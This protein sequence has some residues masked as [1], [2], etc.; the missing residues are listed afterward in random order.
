M[1]RLLRSYTY[2]TGIIIIMMS[3]GLKGYAQNIDLSNVKE[4]I[5]A[6]LK[7]PPVRVN[8]GLSLNTVYTYNDALGAVNLQPF[9][10]IVSGNVNFNIYG[11]N[12]P[13]TFTY[14]NNRVSYTNPSF[15][16]NRFAIHPRYKKWQAH[17]GDISVNYSPYTLS[18]YQ[19]T[20]AAVEYNADKI[21]VQALYGRFAKAVKEDSS[22]IPS[23]KR[24]GWGFRTLYNDGGKKLALTVFHAKD[25]INSIPIPVKPANNAITPMEN[26]A[27]AVEGAYPIL[28]R[29]QV[30]AEYSTSILTRNLSYSGDSLTP[31]GA[32]KYLVGQANGSSSVYHALRAGLNYTIAQSSIG[33]SYERVDPGYQTLGGYFFTNDFENTTINLSQNLWKG[34]ATI[35]INVGLQRDDLNN[36]KES[37]MKRW[38]SSANINLRPSSKLGIGITY[39]NFQSFTYLRNGFEKIN[40]VS[41]YDNLD[42]LNFTQLT[43]NAAVNAN[44]NLQQDEHLASSVFLNLNYM[45]SA[46]RKGDIIR[47]GDL[48]LFINGASG[49]TI[50][51]IPQGLSISAGYNYAYSYA[52][53][54]TDVIQGPLLN[55]SKLFFKKILR[56]NYGVAWNTS[57]TTNGTNNILN[58]RAG[59]SAVLHRKHNLNA[60][61]I[62]QKKAV[63]LQAASSYFMATAGYGF[64][65]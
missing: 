17:I 60:S 49:Y 35:S 15:S 34:K 55:V 33:I 25:N 38:V 58:L 26:T 61:L 48:S 36:N 6:K 40:Q 30:S 7:Q 63:P 18:G 50:T 2:A 13:F 24:M 10:Y 23:Y 5:N 16:F 27:I 32:F 54:S 19:F 3:T 56:T 12:L 20:G 9:T 37:N 31:V 21:S 62:W 45:E 14:S 39:S 51:F 59:A 42:T 65:F 29:L 8:G 41:P 57:H 47:P 4:S 53:Q 11:Y 28:K 46:N 43:Q 64:S 52:A 1:N 44:Y 22:I